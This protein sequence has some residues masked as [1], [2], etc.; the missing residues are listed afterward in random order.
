MIPVII[1]YH[2]AEG[3]NE[4]ILDKIKYTVLPYTLGNLGYSIT[5]CTHQYLSINHPFHLICNRG[6]I[7]E[8]SYFGLL[9]FKES[10]D[11]QDHAFRKDFCGTPETYERVNHCTSNYLDGDSLKD[12]YNRD[13]LGKELCDINLLD[14]V[15]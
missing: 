11:H 9:P 10:K 3:Y 5:R 6:K 15:I 4:D 13:C 2:N 14:F 7:S 12:T 8:I 1:I